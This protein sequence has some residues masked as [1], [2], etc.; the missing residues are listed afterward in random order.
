MRTA[1]L[2]SFECPGCP[3]QAWVVVAIDEN[4]H[5]PRVRS[6]AT[7]GEA[8]AALSEATCTWACEAFARAV[9]CPG[10]TGDLLFWL[11]DDFDDVGVRAFPTRAEA[12][13]ALADFVAADRAELEAAA[14]PAECRRLV[15]AA[16]RST[17]H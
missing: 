8:T 17:G 2:A 16:L 13:R 9:A 3:D 15:D 4:D 5:E 11:G 10:K 12:E 14:D 6:F 7:Y 1:F